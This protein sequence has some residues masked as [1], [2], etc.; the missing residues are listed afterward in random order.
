MT[1]QQKAARRDKITHMMAHLTHAEVDKAYKKAR[2]EKAAAE[3]TPEEKTRPT[4]MEWM[5]AIRA[6]AEEKVA[7]EDQGMGFDF[8]R[9]RNPLTPAVPVEKAEA[10]KKAAVKKATAQK[11]AEKIA[12]K[13]AE[14]VKKKK[15]EKAEAKKKADK[16][17]ADK[18]QEDLLSF[19][20]NWGFFPVLT[21]NKSNNKKNK[22][23]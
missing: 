19:L 20:K 3:G 21:N 10:K 7:E 2:K 12:P 18:K 5:L 14:K 17:K 13:I 4:P 1:P 9:E 11:I 6:A 22:I 16:E 8:V 15:A 23:K